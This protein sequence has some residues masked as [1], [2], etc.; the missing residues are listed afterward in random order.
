MPATQKSFHKREQERLTH[1][2]VGCR[3]E[4]D[5]GGDQGS[6][7]KGMM[8]TDK[9]GLNGQCGYELFGFVRLIRTCPLSPLAAEKRNPDADTSALD[10][11]A[12]RRV[13]RAWTKWC[14]GCRRGLTDT[15]REIKVMERG[16]QLEKGNSDSR[17]GQ[18]CARYSVGVSTRKVDLLLKCRAFQVTKLVTPG[19]CSARL[20]ASAS[21]NAMRWERIL[22]KG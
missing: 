12:A 11:M 21:I 16:D 5:G 19:V 10:R 6:G 17:W 7:G 18:N 14:I 2:C 9:I 3:R 8:T 4:V 15:A 1:S 20:I 13:L 22:A